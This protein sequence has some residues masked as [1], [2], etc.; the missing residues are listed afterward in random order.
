MQVIS[1]RFLLQHEEEEN[2]I[3]E[4]GH[5]LYQADIVPAI[6][7]IWKN[8][9]N[10]EVLR[11]SLF[12]FRRIY[13]F[14]EYLILA[15]ALLD[16]FNLLNF[17]ILDKDR[18][19]L[20]LE[21]GDL[22]CN[23]IFDLAS[24]NI[25]YLQQDKEDKLVEST[26]CGEESFK[27]NSI[28]TY[29]KLN[30][31]M[32]KRL[33][34]NL[35]H[36]NLDVVAV[37]CVLLTNIIVSPHSPL[38]DDLIKKACAKSRECLPSYKGM[39]LVN[40][41]LD[42]DESRVFFD[43]TVLVDDTLAVLKNKPDNRMYMSAAHALQKEVTD[44]FEARERAIDSGAVTLFISNWKDLMA[45]ETVEYL[46]KSPSCHEEFI[47]A[48]GLQWIATT[49]TT[50]SGR[51]L[52]VLDNILDANSEFA[53]A[54]ANTP[55]LIAQMVL[56]LKKGEIDDKRMVERVAY[57]LLQAGIDFHNSLYTALVDFCS[58]QLDTTSVYTLA[59][60]SEKFLIPKEVGKDIK[61]R[62][63]NTPPDHST[64]ATAASLCINLT[65]PRLDDMDKKICVAA[66]ACAKSLY[67]RAQRKLAQFLVVHFQIDDKII[68]LGLE[69]LGDRVVSGALGQQLIS[70]A[71][72]FFSLRADN[73]AIEALE[74]VTVLD[75][76]A[77]SLF[78]FIAVLDAC[79]DRFRKGREWYQQLEA[80]V[81]TRHFPDQQL[82][83]SLLEGIIYFRMCSSFCY[84]MLKANC[85]YRRF[86][87]IRI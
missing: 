40:F 59:M 85:C 15:G 77:T 30:D 39:Q 73:K 46:V 23:A 81:N 11:E 27:N 2:D 10:S 1:Q 36:S 20:F 54:I 21:C 86:N 79:R 17:M 63:F 75:E 42:E 13:E 49:M 12:L 19:E 74:K 60:I 76:D 51:P 35:D 66:T 82:R 41:F 70:K 56:C 69:H 34:E 72:N 43:L 24:R 5:S 7:F 48:G 37:S 50:R 80:F 53:E 71:F 61:I 25:A 33:V 18:F 38:S 32:M 87:R 8:C 26:W 68:E 47:K 52:A 28:G 16:L 62:I 44:D 57:S 3:D 58:S 9:K 67:P 29:I 78:K 22:T 6:I 4:W 65:S 83:P 14:L 45:A 64:F 31:E 55:P 84:F